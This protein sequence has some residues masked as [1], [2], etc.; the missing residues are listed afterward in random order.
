MAR[1]NRNSNQLARQR[2][3]MATRQ[4]APRRQLQ[5]AWDWVVGGQGL[6]ATG[7]PI[8][9]GL[10]SWNGGYTVASGGS[11]TFQPTFIQ[12]TPMSSTPTIG[13][14][15]VDEIRGR[16]YVSSAFANTTPDRFQTAVGI[17]VSDLN[18]TTTLWN[19]RNLLLNLEAC[20]DDYLYLDTREWQQ[21]NLSGITDLAELPCFDLGMSV[22]V[23][24]GGGQAI[25]VTV[26]VSSSAKEDAQP[27]RVTAF[28][29]AR[30]G[31]VA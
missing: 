30:I 14:L 25:N 8:V 11:I 15:R 12:P 26:S 31:P 16:I 5:G 10:F 27:V 21:K 28:F 19:V 1:R 2:G 22:P 23:V 18:V 13:R 3:M 20:R 9:G 4:P 7:L 17:Y 24:M 29:R 6:D